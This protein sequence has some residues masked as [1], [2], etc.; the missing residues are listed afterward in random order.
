MLDGWLAGFLTG[1]GTTLLVFL[2]LGYRIRK[3]VREEAA[4]RE[5]I[6]NDPILG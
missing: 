6:K 5:R 1:V 2:Y 4:E 3:E